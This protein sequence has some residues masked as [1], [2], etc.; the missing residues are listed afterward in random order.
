MFTGGDFPAYDIFFDIIS[1]FAPDE[2]YFIVAADSGLEI[3]NYYGFY[4]DV[5][6]GDMDS[7]SDVALINSFPKSKV[8]RYPQDKDYTDTEL[9]IRFI[10]E[11]QIDRFVLV[12]GGGGRLDQLLGLFYIYFRTFF[13]YLWITRKEVVF[14]MDRGVFNFSIPVGAT[15]SFF[16]VYPD[17]TKADTVGFKWALD[18]LCWKMGDCGISN[19]ISHPK[20]TVNVLSGR[21]LLIWNLFKV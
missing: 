10:K 14:A 5:I 4:P 3:C 19:L 13:P 1:A 9:A 2:N 18:D 20:Q 11:K 15:V 7:L 12:G 6:V 16:P 17:V 8:Y 21:L